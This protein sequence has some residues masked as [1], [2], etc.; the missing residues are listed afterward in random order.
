MLFIF[1]WKALQS[2]NEL[3][4]SG[5]PIAVDWVMEKEQYRNQ[6]EKDNTEYLDPPEATAVTTADP[7]IAVHSEDLSDSTVHKTI[8]DYNDSMMSLQTNLMTRGTL[9]SLFT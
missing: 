3:E 1:D 8:V 9:I 7:G 5:R 4:L 6:L 2:T